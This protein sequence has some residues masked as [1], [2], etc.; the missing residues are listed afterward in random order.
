MLHIQSLNKKNFKIL[1]KNELVGIFKALL[2]FP[3]NRFID[4]LM[5]LRK[6]PVWCI[7]RQNFLTALNESSV[8]EQYT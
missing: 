2:S 6:V 4:I 7:N 5:F 8:R 1:E 3:Q